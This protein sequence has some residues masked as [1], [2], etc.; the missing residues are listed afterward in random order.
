MDGN[1]RWSK[2]SNTSLFKTYYSGAINL[3]NLSNF[4]FSNY[5]LNY[6][7]AF[8]LSKHNLGRNKLNIEILINV[9]EKILDEAQ[10]FENTFNINVLGNINFLPKKIQKKIINLKVD[11]I[12]KKNLLI[13]IN[14]SGLDDIILAS[15]KIPKSSL[16]TNNFRKNLIAGNIPDPEILIRSGGFQRLSDFFLFQLSFTELFFIKKLWPDISKA[17]LK[18]IISKYN[19]I[20]R[21]FGL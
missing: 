19:K 20:E 6:I 8:A 14:Y 4:L 5:D 7:S 13:F 1:L 9:F 10:D 11:N 17:D 12:K 3:F 18:R 21:K 16:N 2:K 15:K